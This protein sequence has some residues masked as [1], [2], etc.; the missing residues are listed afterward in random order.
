MEDSKTKIGGGS[1]LYSICFIL[2]C[3]II[4]IPLLYS[5]IKDITERR[6]GF[7]ITLTVM[8]VV[9]LGL[10]ISAVIDMLVKIRKE[11]IAQLQE[12]SQIRD[13]KIIQTR[14]LV[15]TKEGMK[16]LSEEEL[17][18]LQASVGDEEAFIDMGISQTT[19]IINED[20][21]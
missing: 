4:F 9:F 17:K 16:W 2:F 12:E 7:G 14:K 20:K 15:Q 3:S 8:G 6:Y 5:G 13:E 21:K 10:T 11:K 18:Q 1:I 19:S